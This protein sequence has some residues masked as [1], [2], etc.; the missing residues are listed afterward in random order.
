MHRLLSELFYVCAF[1]LAQATP[2][3]PG[4]AQQSE[5]LVHCNAWI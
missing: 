3:E 2:P 5:L 1:S 4:W